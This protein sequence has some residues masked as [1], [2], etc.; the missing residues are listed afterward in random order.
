MRIWDLVTGKELKQFKGHQGEVTTLSLAADGK[1]LA[2]G[3]KDTTILIWDISALKAAPPTLAELSSKDVEALWADL[4][5]ADGIKAGKSIQVLALA[6]RTSVPFLKGQLKPVVP[7]EQK[8]L[9][10]LI[11]DLESDNFPVRSKALEDLEKLGELAVPP[12]TR[13]LAGDPPPETRKRAEELLEKLSG[14]LLSGERLRLVRAVEVLEKAGTPEARQVLEILARGA[15][16]ALPTRE[17]QDALTR[18]GSGK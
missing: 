11:A 10:R 7:V 17:A 8:V 6:S 13:V 2:S 16:G 9:N 1:T 12:L 18:L 14:S 15:P 4:L 3:S 5:S